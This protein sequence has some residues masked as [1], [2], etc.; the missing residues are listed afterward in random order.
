MKKIVKALILWFCLGA[1]YYVIE[2]IWRIPRGGYANIAMLPIG[3]LCGLAVGYINQIPKFYQMKV[4]HQSLIG[5]ALVLCVEFLAGL[6][7]NVWLGLGLWDYS[8]LPFNLMGQ[9][10]LIYG[11]LWVFLMPFAIWLED[12]LRWGF[13]RDR[14]I[15]SLGSIYKEFFKGQ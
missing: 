8:G 6:I 15:Y 1:I 5:A 2:G 12:T 14:E 11:V 10:C 3:G 4:L 7:L 13:W 9:I